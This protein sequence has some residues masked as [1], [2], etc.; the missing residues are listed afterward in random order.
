MNSL[1]IKKDFTNVFDGSIEKNT[2]LLSIVEINR[3]RMANL[4][5]ASQF[6]TLLRKLNLYL[7][8]AF[9]K[10]CYTYHTKCCQ[11]ISCGAHYLN[12]GKVETYSNLTLK[13]VTVQQT[14]HSPHMTEPVRPRSLGTLKDPELKLNLSHN[15][16]MQDV[17]LPDKQQGS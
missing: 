3:G 7:W 16:L 15:Y 10:K 13:W 4:S 11:W 14:M 9:H 17:K 1:S 12:C 8:I 2:I 6:P 5:L